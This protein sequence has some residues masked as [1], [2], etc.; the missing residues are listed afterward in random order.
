MPGRKFSIRTSADSNQLHQHR[1]ALFGLQIE[2]D[3]LLVA[4]DAE[5]IGA[6]AADERL[7][8]PGVVAVAR[9]FDLDDLGAHVAEEHGAER[10]GEDAGEIEDAQP[11]ERQRAGGI[12]RHELSA[13]I[14]GHVV[15]TL[16]LEPRS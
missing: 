6:P 12:G 1:P 15:V 13:S 3:A 11:G 5:E 16:H 4:V 14:G 8:R 7:P 2:G 9:V 10:T